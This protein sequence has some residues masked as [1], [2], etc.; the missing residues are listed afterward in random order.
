MRVGKNKTGGCI[1]AVAGRLSNSISYV[2]DQQ[3][4]FVSVFLE[5]G[6]IDAEFFRL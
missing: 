4:L 5:E 1:D 2:C 6:F 3:K